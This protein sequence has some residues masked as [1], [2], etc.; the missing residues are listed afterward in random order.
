MVR[1]LRFA[2]H[3]LY[4]QH[5][6][7]TFDSCPMKFRKRYL[8]NLKWDTFPDESIRKNIE[9]GNS[10]HLLAHR[11][12]MGIEPAPAEAYEEF[13]E[14]E[15]WMKN[16][17]DGFK[18]NPDFRYLPEYKLRMSSGEVKLEANFDLLIVKGDQI[19][20]WDWKTHG[21]GK[22]NNRDVGKRLRGSLQTM[23][24][25]YVLK[26]Q[27]RLVA[28][29]EVKASGISMHYWQPEP[30][31]TLAD[32]MYDDLLHEQFGRIIKG[33]IHNILSYDYESFNKEKYS[34]HCRVCEFNWYCNNDRVDFSAIREDE[35][36]M[37]ELDWELA[38][39][40]Y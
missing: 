13:P 12:F 3:F 30:A 16:L 5:S 26:E 38:E 6:L 14:L 25:M 32:I 15:R 29:K 21:G 8:E 2:H 17:A 9:M 34:K 20:I 39:E 10:F 22:R 31:M 36:L 24:Y 28:G 40:V 37:E 33:K 4:T 27:S 23:V 11:Y 35:D 18:I 7:A 19:E 1:D